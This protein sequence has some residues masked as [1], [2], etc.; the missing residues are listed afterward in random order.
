[1]LT[2]LDTNVLVSATIFPNSIPSRAVLLAASKGVILFSQETLDEL[3]EVLGRK[4]FD[5]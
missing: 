2:V 3:H 5:R 4:K 1:M